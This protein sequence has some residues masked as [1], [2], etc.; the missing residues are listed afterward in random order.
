MQRYALNNNIEKYNR[1]ETDTYAPD[2]ASWSK[3]IHVYES[4]RILGIYK[5]HRQASINLQAECSRRGGHEAECLKARLATLLIDKSTQEGSVPIVDATMIDDVVAN[6]LS[7]PVSKRVRRLLFYIARTNGSID[8]KLHIWVHEPLLEG[9]LGWSESV[10]EAEL[11]LLLSHLIE[12][13]LIAEDCQYT[14]AYRVTVRGFEAVEESGVSEIGDAASR[15]QPTAETQSTR[16]LE[17][18]GDEGKGTRVQ[19]YQV[20]LSFAGEQRSYVEEVAM[21]LRHRSTEVFYD[22]FEQ[23]NL[24]GRSGAEAFYDAFARQSAFVVMFISKEYLEKPWTRHERRSALSRMTHEDRAF[25]LPVR[26]DESQVPGLPADIIYLNASKYTPAVLATVICNKIGIN[27]LDRKASEVPPPAMASLVGEVVID[28]SSYDGRYIIGDGLLLFET[29]WGR[30]SNTSIHIVNHPPSIHK[31]ALVKECC[32][33]SQVLRT[34]TLDFTSSVRTVDVGTLV[35]LQNTYG[36]YAVVRVLEIDG[37]RHGAPKDKL[38]FRYAIQPN[39]S[40][41]FCEFVDL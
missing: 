30:A 18:G 1:W 12:S 4:P 5:I 21:H 38:R 14:G 23:A 34:N 7:L 9:A 26:F 11:E 35:V 13:K 33:I 6:S 27:P 28:Y 3:D 29:K 39:G 37:E 8:E 31:I 10:T 19:N 2:R 36:F 41:N 40:D 17:H 32:S 15:S 20:A 25:I 24:W 16:A 22:G